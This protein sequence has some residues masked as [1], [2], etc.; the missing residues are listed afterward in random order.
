MDFGKE[1]R[2]DGLEQPVLNAIDMAKR[3]IELLTEARD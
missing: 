2:V 1:G 3:S